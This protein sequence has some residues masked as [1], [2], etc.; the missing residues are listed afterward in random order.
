MTLFELFERTTEII[1][2]FV[3]IMPIIASS[4]QVKSSHEDFIVQ[5]VA[6]RSPNQVYN[7]NTKLVTCLTLAEAGKI[8]YFSSS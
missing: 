2:L 3:A 4:R 7:L 1:L 5:G 8:K 6:F